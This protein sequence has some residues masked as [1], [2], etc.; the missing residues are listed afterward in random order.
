MTSLAAIYSRPDSVKLVVVDPKRGGK[1]SLRSITD[2]QWYRAVIDTL[3]DDT[4]TVTFIDFETSETVMAVELRHIRSE[5]VRQAPFAIHSC[6]AG[7]DNNTEWTPD[8]NN[9]FV[10]KT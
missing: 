4:A 1:C 6:A 10:K 7:R 2:K 9:V 5:F 8:E 3:E